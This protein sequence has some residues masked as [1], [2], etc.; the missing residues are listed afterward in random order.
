MKRLAVV[1]LAVVWATAAFAQVVTNPTDTAPAGAYNSSPPT[2]TAGAFCRLQVDVN[3]NLKTTASGGSG[4]TVTANQGTAAAITGGWPVIDGAGTDT[5][6]SFTGAGAGTV[7]AAIDGYASAKIQIKGTYA[8]FTVNTLASSDGGTT[9]V[10]IQCASVAGGTPATSF[11]LTANQ[12]TEIACGHQSGDD[13]LILSTSAGPA[14]GTAN[15]VISPSAFPSND[16]STISA[17]VGG[18]AASGSAI[19]GNPVLIAGANAGNAVNVAVTSGGAL[20]ANGLVASGGANSGNPLKT[21]GVFNTTAP[22]VTNAQIVDLQ[23]TNRGSQIIAIDQT[24]DITTNGV[25]IAPTAGAGAGITP[26][27]SAS[28][29]NNHVLKASAGNLYSVYAQNLTSTTGFLV[30]LNSTTS[31]AD[32]AITPLECVQLPPNGNASISY[33]P[34]PAGVFTTGITAVLT[35][36]TTCFTKTTGVITGFIHGAVK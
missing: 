19:V 10:P 16:G 12:T 22:T 18:Q 30:V 5:S 9:T 17:S 29:E 27:V 36:A 31:P 25:E 4:G 14:T 34:G 26:I 1:A 21:G 6:G 15:V 24:T 23:T 33:N 8:G 32:G 28:A 11:V 3:G 20:I 35:S 7:T 2:C 13:T